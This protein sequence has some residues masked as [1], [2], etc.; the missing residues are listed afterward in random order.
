V[1]G[2]QGSLGHATWLGESAADH[3]TMD[4]EFALC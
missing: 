2:E 4:A 1:L 3:D